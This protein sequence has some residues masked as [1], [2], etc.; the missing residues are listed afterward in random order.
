MAAMYSG[1]ISENDFLKDKM[2]SRLER[3]DELV[4]EISVSHLS[5]KKVIKIGIPFRELIQSVKDEGAD[6]VVMGPKGRSNLEDILFGSTAE[7]MFRHCPVP[8]LSIRGNRHR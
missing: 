3:I 8:L 1:A 7:K 4:K 5:V 2:E 6:I